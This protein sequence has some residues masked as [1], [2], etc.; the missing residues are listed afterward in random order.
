MAL[1]SARSA[2]RRGTLAAALTPAALR[3]HRALARDS[4][5]R[6]R[7]LER[8]QRPGDFKAYLR[9]YF[10]QYRQLELARTR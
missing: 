1:I 4:Q 6:L 8:T 9:Q 3:R 5:Q 2:H 7:D 10:D